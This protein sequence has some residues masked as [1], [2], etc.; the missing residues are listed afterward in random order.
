MNYFRL[1]HEIL[2]FQH[3]GVQSICHRGCELFTVAFIATPRGGVPL[4]EPKPGVIPPAIMATLDKYGIPLG[5]ANFPIIKKTALNQKSKDTKP[6]IVHDKNEKEREELEKSINKRIDNED[7]RLNVKRLIS[8][9]N[10]PKE[11]K[12]IHVT[13]DAPKAPVKV[14]D[15]KELHKSE[16]KH[17][18]HDDIFDIE[19]CPELTEAEIADF[20]KQIAVQSVPANG[21]TDKKHN[22]KHAVNQKTIAGENKPKKSFREEVFSQIKKDS[23]S[24]TPKKMH[25]EKTFKGDEARAIL[26][27]VRTHEAHNVQNSLHHASSNIPHGPEKKTDLKGKVAKAPNSPSSKTTVQP[28]P[29]PVQ[30]HPVH[31]NRQITTDSSGTDDRKTTTPKSSNPAVPVPLNRIKQIHEVN[32]LGSKLGANK[33]NLIHPLLHITFLKPRPRVQL[34]VPQQVSIIEIVKKK[35][36]IDFE[37][38]HQEHMEGAAMC[39]EI[40]ERLEQAKHSC[41]HGEYVHQ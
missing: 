19:N 30:D 12:E 26:N 22:D 16:S 36:N 21:Q 33:S 34:M 18:V 9:E 13:H 38:L 25:F 10:E 29:L 28:L 2:I 39:P 8:G 4:V 35:N 5:P 7:E 3:P 15:K 31:A 24:K 14:E 23:Q 37:K 27:A 32:K 20:K 41:R 11:I 6:V 40:N 17:V 1:R